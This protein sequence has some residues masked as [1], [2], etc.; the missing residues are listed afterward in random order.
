[1]EIG[2]AVCGCIVDSGTVVRPCGTTD[3]CCQDLPVRYA[4]LAQQIRSVFADRD[5]DTFWGLLAEDARWG[6]DDHPN[7]CRSRSDVIATFK[8]L[9]HE[10][11]RGEVAETATGPR[12]VIARLR[13]EWPDPH[14]RYRG[15]D[16]YQAY[17]VRDGKIAEIQRHDDRASAL[18]AISN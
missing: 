12:G 17:L 6:D 16:F 8:R 4:D 9:L 2:C 15:E 1:M 5:V 14:D 11:V 18:A 7:Q 10:G 13:V 3:C